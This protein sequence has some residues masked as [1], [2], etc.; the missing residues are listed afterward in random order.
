MFCQKRPLHDLSSKSDI[1]GQP[2]ELEKPWDAEKHSKH[3][4]HPYLFIEN[5]DAEIDTVHAVE[6]HSSNDNGSVDMKSSD[7]KDKD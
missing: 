5:L 4:K 6:K 2:S 1:I 3:H 7:I